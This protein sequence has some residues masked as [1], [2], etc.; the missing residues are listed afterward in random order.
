MKHR[1]WL[2]VVA[3]CMAALTLAGCGTS[4]SSKNSTS[5][6]VSAKKYKKPITVIENMQ[7]SGLSTHHKVVI[8]KEPTKIFAN[9][10][11]NADIMFDL[12]LANRMVGYTRGS[13]MNNEKYPG[14]NKVKQIAKPGVD[15]EGVS[16]EKVLSTNCDF[17]IGGSGV[18]SDKNLSLSFCKKNGITP[19]STYVSTNNGS[20]NELYKDYR[21][22][23]KIFRVEKRANNRI[24][25]MKAT[26]NSVHQ[27]IGDDAYNH[28]VKIFD[29]DSGESTPFTACQGMPGDVFKK[30]GAVSIFNDVH[31]GWSTVSWEQVAKRDPDAIVVND[32]GSHNDVKNKI[33][34]L[35]TNKQT[36][37]LR[38]VKENRIYAV[39]CA[40]MIGSAG[41]AKTVQK[42][43]KQLY[44]NDFK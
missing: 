19:Y 15:I 10:D 28:P 6:T 27:A 35:K 23:G 37:N 31:K 5:Q 29:Y 36:K 4:S 21:T 30:A 12:G 41:S 8:R 3:A 11:A 22:L 25:K 40:N 24:N 14:R 1:K 16:K 32:Y 44:P 39:N 2:T 42:L 17:I 26:L 43:A 7:P 38:A 13:C 20:F 33:K 18:F 9:G 34:F